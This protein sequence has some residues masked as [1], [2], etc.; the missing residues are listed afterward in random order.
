[1]HVSSRNESKHTSNYSSLSLITADEVHDL[2]SKVWE[3]AE[4]ALPAWDPQVT[5]WSWA[6][7]NWIFKSSCQFWVPKGNISNLNFRD[8]KPVQFLHV[9]LMC[10]CLALLKKSYKWPPRKIK[11]EIKPKYIAEWVSPTEN[12]DIIFFFFIHITSLELISCMISL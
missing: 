12:T 4:W 9:F 2:V 3:S 1:M 8:A 11:Q 5:K 6:K 10:K 7:H